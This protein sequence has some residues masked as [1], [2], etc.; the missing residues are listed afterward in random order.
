MTIDPKTGILALILGA[1]LGILIAS[2]WQRSRERAAAESAGEGESSEEQSHLCRSM[3]LAQDAEVDALRY[4]ISA[5]VPLREKNLR[6]QT[7][8]VVVVGAD[9]SCSM[10]YSASA[11]GCDIAMGWS[12]TLDEFRGSVLTLR[13]TYPVPN[14]VLDTYGRSDAEARAAVTK[15]CDY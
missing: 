15:L 14:H 2:D 12:N 13:E 11:D 4:A 8:G 5:K 7:L 10:Q 6:A 1:L 9:M 3:R